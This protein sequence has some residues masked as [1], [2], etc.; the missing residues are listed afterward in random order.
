MQE[1]AYEVLTHL[2]LGEYTA[3]F[4]H[5]TNISGVLDSPVP[6]FWNIEKK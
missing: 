4:S 3:N 6:F 5:R 2:P 1:R